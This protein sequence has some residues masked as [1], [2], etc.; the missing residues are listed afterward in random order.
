[1]ALKRKLYALTVLRAEGEVERNYCWACAPIIIRQEHAALGLLAAARIMDEG[2]CHRCG[3][4]AESIGKLGIT[5]SAD[6]HLLVS[7]DGARF[8]G[9]PMTEFDK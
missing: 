7:V 1:M 4:S 5:A 3:I 9:R 8:N 2:H 6:S